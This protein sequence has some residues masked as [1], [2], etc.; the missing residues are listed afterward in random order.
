[1]HKPVLWITRKLSA[2]TEARATR[3]Y[4]TLLSPEDDVVYQ[5]VLSSED[6][7]LRVAYAAAL[8]TD[9]TVRGELVGMLQVRLNAEALLA[10]TRNRSGLGPSGETLIAIRAFTGG[11]RVLKGNGPGTPPMWEEVELRGD[12]DPVSRAMSGEEGAFA[13]DPAAVVEGP[14][15][16]RRRRPLP[17]S[18]LA[19]LAPQRRRDGPCE[20]DRPG[21]TTITDGAALG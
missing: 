5:G 20:Q 9:G 17:G 2:A 16:S 1:M 15:G 18:L 21:S 7:E 6:E 14:H 11:V 4:Q 19:G 10:L 13:E 8:T 12:S 3:D